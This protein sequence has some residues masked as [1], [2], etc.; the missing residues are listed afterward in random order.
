MGFAVRFYSFAKKENSTARPTGTA[1]EFSCVIK[2]KS[3]ILNP[4]I[5]LDIGLIESPA[6]YNY[7]YIP[8]FNRYYFI[9]D[10]VFSDRLWEAELSVD[11]LATYK[12][13]I[14]SAN[15]YILRAANSYDGRVVDNLY[16]TKVNCSYNST[17]I[18]S[19]WASIVNG[20]YVIGVVSKVPVYGSVRYYA[21]DR[22]SMQDLVKGL[23]D[24]TIKD[25]DNH[26]NLTDA[27]E[28]LQLALVDPLQYIKSAVFIPISY[29]NIPG[30]PVPLGLLNVFNYKVKVSGS[31]KIITDTPY[32]NL[33]F[34]LATKKHP[35][36][37]ARGNYVNTSPYTLATL[38]FPPFGTIELDTTV[39]CD[40]S[41]ITC[42]VVLDTL[43]GRGILEVKANGIL[44]NRL[45][46]Q[47]GVPVQLSQVT[48]DYMGAINGILGTAGS[49]AGAVGN[50]MSGN[51]AGAVAGGVNAVSGIGNA[52]TSLVPRSQSTGQGG[53]YAQLYEAPRLDFQFFEIVEDD[54]DHNGRPLCQKK[55]ISSVA[56]YMLIQ[57]GDIPTIGT[58]EE[59]RS[60]RSYLES[61]F[62]YE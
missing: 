2:T 14:G 17:V 31:T 22:Q 40:V 24:D 49:I 7:A 3:G 58:A 44:I 13:Q 52:A 19:P 55:T 57:D 42:E 48:R 20:I 51:I 8:T 26:F 1:R 27:S 41:S 54:P 29:S 43:N 59:N 16:P 6:Q 36:T 32:V 47:I 33:S 25:P 21:L 5:Q 45:E 9:V 12:T 4:T 30:V 50:A 62:Y 56:G 37:T 18:N 61:G 15:L 11:V 35:Q 38:T 53:S 46:S 34:T 23:L 28:G 39:L 10:W 60:I